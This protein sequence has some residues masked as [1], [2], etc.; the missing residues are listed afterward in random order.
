MVQPVTEQP[1]I[2]TSRCTDRHRPCITGTPADQTARIAAAGDRRVNNRAV[3]QSD[4]TNGV[5]GGDQRGGITVRHSDVR[6]GNGQILNGQAAAGP[7]AAD[8]GGSR[9]VMVRLLPSS[10][11]LSAAMEG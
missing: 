3:D 8:Q 4:L 6:V 11:M 5:R 1:W 7:D 9:P 2:V 10:V